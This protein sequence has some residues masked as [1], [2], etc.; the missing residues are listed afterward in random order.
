MQRGLGGGTTLHQTTSF[1]INFIFF[2]VFL[3]KRDEFVLEF[4]F[5]L[6]LIEKKMK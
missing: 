6:S 1:S 3:K 4:F 5:I 2:F